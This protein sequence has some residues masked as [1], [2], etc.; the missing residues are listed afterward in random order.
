MRIRRYLVAGTV[1]VLAALHLLMTV[2]YL[3]PPNLLRQQF[4]LLA[5][6]YMHPLFYQNWHLF[7]PNPGVTTTKLAVRYRID[8]VWSEWFDPVQQLQDQHYAYRVTGHGKLI[9]VYRDVALELRRSYGRDVQACLQE[10]LDAGVPAREALGPGGSCSEEAVI[11]RLLEHPATAMA[12]RFAIATSLARTPDRDPDAYQFKLLEF[13][14]LNY[15]ERDKVH[16]RWSQVLEVVF[17]PLEVIV[18]SEPLQEAPLASA[19]NSASHPRL[20]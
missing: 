20:H 3:S 15:S 1:L 6:V 4:G 14:P 9:Y 18:P 7:S 12:Y 16:Q 17:P 8:D 19:A 5:D 10:Q 13:Y 2:V 11:L